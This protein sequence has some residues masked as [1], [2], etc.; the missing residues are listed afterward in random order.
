[1][2]FERSTSSIHLIVARRRY[3][4]FPSEGNLVDRSFV[5]LLGILSRTRQE[6]SYVMGPKQERIAGKAESDERERMKLFLCR[7]PRLPSCA[8][9]EPRPGSTKEEIGKQE[10]ASEMLVKR[11]LCGPPYLV[12]AEA[13]YIYEKQKRAVG[14]TKQEAIKQ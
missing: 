8:I 13:N 10:A 6:K 3:R 5:G 4:C 11:I 7:P 14:N 2:F 1:M 9:R 12:W